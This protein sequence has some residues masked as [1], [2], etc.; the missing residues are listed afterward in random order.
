VTR[1][2]PVKPRVDLRHAF[3]GQ[4]YKRND[5]L[6]LEGDGCSLRIMLVVGVRLP[7]RLDELAELTFEPGQPFSGRCTLDGKPLPR[8]LV[9]DLGHWTNVCGRRCSQSADSCAGGS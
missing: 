5:V 1:G 2:E 3:P 7:G 6:P 4:A 9:R 8:A